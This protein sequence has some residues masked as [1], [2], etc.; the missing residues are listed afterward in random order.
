MAVKAKAAVKRLDEIRQG[1]IAD[2]KETKKVTPLFEDKASK[3]EPP[4]LS[5]ETKAEK[6]MLEKFMDFYR[7]YVKDRVRRKDKA[8]NELIAESEG[9]VRPEVEKDKRKSG[10]P[11]KKPES[12]K[13]KEPRPE[14]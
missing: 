11:R 1:N 4:Q 6:E 7:L 5:P 2:E 8:T 14:E 10:M 9:M 3:V 12:S 13:S